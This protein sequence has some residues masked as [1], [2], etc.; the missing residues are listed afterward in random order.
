MSTAPAP[1][2]SSMDKLI[3]GCV[4]I[5]LVS[6]LLL[7]AGTVYAIVTQKMGV[8]LAIAAGAYFLVSLLFLG[9]VSVAFLQGHLGS[10]KGVEAPKME[11]F[12]LEEEWRQ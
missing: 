5:F 6:L 4:K 9:I 1:K 12:K 11:I 2:G 3:R 7:I 8:Y 10:S